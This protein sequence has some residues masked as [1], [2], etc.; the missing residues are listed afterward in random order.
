MTDINGGKITNYGL[1][2]KLF[3]LFFSRSYY[4]MSFCLIDLTQNFRIGGFFLL[5]K[6]ISLPIFH[7]DHFVFWSWDMTKS[8]NWR[9]LQLMRKAWSSFLKSHSFMTHP[10]LLSMLATFWL[11]EGTGYHQATPEGLLSALMLTTS[12]QN[13]ACRPLLCEPL[14]LGFWTTE[15]FW[16]SSFSGA[17][18]MPLLLVSYSPLVI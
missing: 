12:L 2:L 17:N 7:C 9:T 15:F 1:I 4:G 18:A 11:Q 8:E 6:Q 16:F 10:P 3:V 14:F 13:F 5:R